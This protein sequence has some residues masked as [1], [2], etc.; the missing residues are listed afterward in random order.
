LWNF[1]FA[2]GFI[3]TFLLFGWLC[4]R[5]PLR[6]LLIW[7]T[8]VAVPQMVPLLFVKTV[9]EALIGGFASGLMGGVATA[10]YLDLMIRS[11]PKGLEGTMLMASNA[12]YAVVSQWGNLLGSKLYEHFHTF[13]VCAV[14]ITIVYALILPTL[15][16][17][18]KRLTATPDGVA[19][20]G[21]FDQA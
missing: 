19:P 10:A 20:E 4:R 5:V 12:L 13:T 8:V 14:S 17:V 9:Q 7:G 18:P 11:C 1:W 16:L 6:T 3:P 21:G 2:G 15:L